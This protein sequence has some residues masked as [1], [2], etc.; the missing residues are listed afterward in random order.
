MHESIL[1]ILEKE[2]QRQ[3][4]HF[5]LIASEN[6]ASDAV[7][8]LC[9][10]IFTNKYAE[11]YPEKRY[12]NGCEHMDEIETLAINSVCELYNC[13]FANVQP[14]SGVNA[15]TAVYQAFLKPGDTILGMDLASGGHLSHGAKPTLS[16]KV[17]TAHAY[18]VNEKGYLDYNEIEELAKVCKPKMIVAGASAYSRQINWKSFREIADKVGAFLLCD[19]AHYSGLIAG[20]A[21]DSPL[22]YA[23]VVTSTTHKTLRGPRGGMILWN[24]EDYSKKINSA[25]FPG[26]QGGPLMNIIAA[27]AQCYKEALHPSFDEYIEA[28]IENAKAMAEVFLEK[29]Y[30]IITKGTDSHILLLDLSDKSISGREAADLL[31]VNDITVNKNGVPNDPRNFIETSGIR[32]G[33]AA[34]TTRNKSSWWFENLAERMVEIL[35]K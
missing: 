34:E 27:K 3:E 9:G 20:N 1:E 18:G 28:V 4:T 29:G 16:G 17:Y 12:Y 26:T 35:E 31:E 5:E 11:G 2:K 23:D 25:I 7:R 33:T 21:Y 30:N 13:N 6:F 15:N 8:S 14:H 19:M 32:I 24:N 22:P 10:S